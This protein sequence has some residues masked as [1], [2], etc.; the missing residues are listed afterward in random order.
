[1]HLSLREI[2]PWWK[3]VP[4]I[5]LHSL[6]LMNRGYVVTKTLLILNTRKVIDAA[7]F[8]ENDIES[9]V[10]RS[11]Y[12]YYVQN[13][14]INRAAFVCL[15]VCLFPYSSEVLWRI[16]PNL[17]GVCR[18]TSELPLRGQ[19]VNGST[20]Q[21]VKRHFFG[22]D[23]TRLRPHRSKRHGVFVQQKAHSV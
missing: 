22:A 13:H 19:R 1:M 4:T 15:Y 9:L 7:C 21:R 5:L 16:S 11:L 10:W 17:V 20:G 18:W 6:V 3:H 14:T 8:E 2:K 12:F 23:D